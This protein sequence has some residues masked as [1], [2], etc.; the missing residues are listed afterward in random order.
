MDYGKILLDG[1]IISIIMS[2]YLVALLAYNPRIFLNPGDY[3]ADVIAAAPP[4]TDREKRLAIWTGILFLLLSIALPLWSVVTFK[5]AAQS[6]FW[7]LTAHAFGVLLIPFLVDLIFLDWLMFCTITPAFLVIPGTEG[8]SG[9]KDK[10]FHLKA[11]TK[12]LFLY[13]IPFSLI[14]AALA[15]LF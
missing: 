7:L 12:G 8:F 4:K 11:H 5:F 1:G 13:M 10:M 2:V 14:I 9:Y 3:P 6:N 15:L